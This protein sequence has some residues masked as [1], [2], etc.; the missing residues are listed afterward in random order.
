[1]CF[2]NVKKLA[3]FEANICFR[4]HFIAFLV[5]K[6]VPSVTFK[7]LSVTFFASLFFKVACHL[8]SYF[9]VCCKFVFFYTIYIPLNNKNIMILAEFVA[10]WN[11]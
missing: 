3:R 4:F 7:D 10:Y 1:M 8:I 5:S 6:S 11:L 9:K 2:V